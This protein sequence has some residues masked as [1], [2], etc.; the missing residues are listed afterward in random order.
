MKHQ[1]MLSRQKT[2]LLVIDVQEKFG[3][4]IPGFDA[5]VNNVLRL[6]LGCQMFGMPVIFTE[7][8]P[9]GLGRTVDRIRRQFKTFAALE[10]IE[11]SAAD[12]ENVSKQLD[13]LNLSAVVVC[14][15]ETHVCVNQTV[16]ALLARG[17]KVHVVADAVGSRHSLDHNLGLRKM[18]TS[19][20][21]ITTTEMCLFELAEKA[22]TNEF[23][24]IQ[25]MVRGPKRI[26]DAAEADVAKKPADHKEAPETVKIVVNQEVIDTTAPA[27]QKKT[28]APP[29]K[30]VRQPAKP[31]AAEPDVEVIE[32]VG[33]EPAK[34]DTAATPAAPAAAAAEGPSHADELLASIDKKIES[35]DVPD[36][37]GALDVDKDIADL[38]EILKKQE[39][40]RASGAA[41]GDSPAEEK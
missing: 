9:K 10:K 11:L 3:P 15:I 23:K 40:E 29:Q 7:Q 31:K 36:G 22:Q 8:Y 41:A 35:L 19:G 39:P 2:G 12:N 16:H 21:L 25:K 20:A 27:P 37:S 38:E 33:I 26:P 34:S 24:N 4:V 6:V 13:A 32:L 17:M 14:G 5:L 30:T 28:A 1:N 18:E